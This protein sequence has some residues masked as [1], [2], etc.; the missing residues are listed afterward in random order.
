MLS[1]KSNAREIHKQ[2]RAIIR[3]QIPFI[4]MKTINDSLYLAQKH[5]REEVLPE[6]FTLRNKRSQSG[7]RVQRATKDRLTGTIGSVD[8]WMK[9]QS[10]GDEKSS[11]NLPFGIRDSND[12]LIPRGLFPSK[13]G[14]GSDK[15]KK[16]QGKT[17]FIIS[18][19]G[20]KKEYGASGGRD[21]AG[22]YR[23]KK[24]HKDRRRR[25]RKKYNGMSLEEIKADMRRGFTGIFIRTGKG[26]G[27]LKLLYKI[28]SHV[29]IP[30]TDWLESPTKT[31]VEENIEAIWEANFKEA[32]RTAR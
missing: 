16:I 29:R 15:P 1:F 21:D 32:M 20:R 4:T 11:A 30:A 19:Q 13:L 2:Q 10:E 23:K 3:N 8:P 31:I 18:T 9:T 12:K 6:K 22:R 24:A 5:L 17:P 28:A 27:D 26:R 14:L 25:A 7:I